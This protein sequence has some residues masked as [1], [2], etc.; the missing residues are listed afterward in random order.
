[1]S[2]GK[3]ISS[4]LMCHAPIVIPDIA[5]P[6]SREVEQTTQAMR[7]VARSVLRDS[8]DVLVVL[9]PHTP[10]LRDAFGLVSGPLTGDFAM[11]GAREIRIAL[12]GAPE[13]N[14]AIRAAAGPLD[15]PIVE[16]ELDGVDHGAGVPLFF[17]EEAG[18]RGPTVLVGFPY[19]TSHA[20]CRRMGEALRVAAEETGKRVVVLASGDMSHRLIPGAPSGFHPDGAVFDATFKARLESGDVMSAVNIEDGLRAHA[21]EDVID[22]V[23]IA[24]AS[25][26]YACQGLDVVSYEGPFGVGYLVATLHHKASDPSRAER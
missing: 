21:A 6:R 24:G 17:L 1:M 25:F 23:D 3:I 19:S 22:S 5:G 4:V 2:Q 13:M 8:P 18:W 11:F 16:I 10:R 12:P 15:V 7:E 9:S 26:G 14:A 20:L